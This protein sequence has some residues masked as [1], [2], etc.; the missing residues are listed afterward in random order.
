MDICLESFDYTVV[1]EDIKEK[2]SAIIKKIK[3][4]LIGLIRKI[5]HGIMKIHE[6]MEN[7]SS[8]RKRGNSNT[9]DG[10]ASPDKPENSDDSTKNTKNSAPESSSSNDT[11]N[12]TKPKSLSAKDT[13][14]LPELEK[15]KTIKLDANQMNKLEMLNTNGMSI[16]TSEAEKRRYVRIMSEMSLSEI[17]D[18]VDSNLRHKTMPV[19]QVRTVKQFEF[20]HNHCAD[21]IDKMTEIV[22][23]ACNVMNANDE[24]SKN[25]AIEKLINTTKFVD[26]QV[27]DLNT[28]EQAMIALTRRNDEK[29]DISSSW[30]GMRDIGVI[31]DIWNH[32]FSEPDIMYTMGHG[33]TNYAAEDSKLRNAPTSRIF[34]AKLDHCEDIVTHIKDKAYDDLDDQ[35]NTLG[36]IAGCALRGIYQ[37]DSIV[38]ACM[39]MQDIILESLREV[40]IKIYKEN[41]DS[42]HEESYNF[43][44]IV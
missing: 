39:S 21:V 6:K 22:D 23:D 1:N 9:A 15:H 34:N 43:C 36:T 17:Q 3:E 38:C 19:L 12:P 10:K 32:V 5:K 30:V 41:K 4:A 20:W 40:A 18:R 31:K 26:S 33:L 11:T 27:H 2:A 16:F 29:E 25:R 8:K 42:I 37:L 28:V 24:Q 14:K 7:M 13:A 44:S 35:L